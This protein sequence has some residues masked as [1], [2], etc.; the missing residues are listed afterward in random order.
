MITPAASEL[1]QEWVTKTELMTYVRCPYTYSLLHRGELDPADLFDDFILDLIAQGQEFHDRVDA[2]APTI[3]LTSVE[4]L[5]ELLAQGTIILH[6]PLL[7]NVELKIYGMP[8][9]IDPQGGALWPI[10]YK[11]HKDVQPHDEIEL[12]FYW[13]LLAPRRTK[14]T[15]DP[16]GLMV[17]RR[18][19]EPY[20]VEV[21]IP[22]HRIAQVTSYLALV[23][24]ARITPMEPRLCRC[25]VCTGVRRDEVLQSVTARRHV[26]LLFGVG[27]EYE[28]ALSDLGVHDY[29]DLLEWD[30]GALAAALRQAG[31]RRC[32]P[33]MA[34]R[35][36]HHARAYREGSAQ[37]FGAPPPVGDG[38]IVLDLEYLTQ[39]FGER[40]WLAGTVVAKG[41]GPP[42]V[43]QLWADDTDAD[44]QSLLEDLGRLLDTHPQLPIVTWAGRG[45]DLPATRRAAGRLGTKDPLAGRNHCDLYVWAQRSFRLPASGLGLKGLAEY[46][47]FP[48]N[49]NVTGGME[50]Q[51]LYLR[52]RDE[53]GRSRQ[54]TKQQLLDYNRDDL[55]STLALTRELKALASPQENR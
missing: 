39:P 18:D 34:E 55:D 28:K 16:R 51:G 21:A 42:L 17:L 30:P 22:P 7:F 33:S 35:W 54:D 20:P 14:G 48:R 46:F 27:R 36:Q 49:S 15:D 26:S 9:G 40:V 1:S 45:A 23:R 53:S 11:S 50:A 25:H 6:P 4:E 19:G 8:D 32:S 29:L 24:Q 13:L 10:E 12:A 38:F 47:A 44:E 2:M 41:F 3:E 52:M 43:H 37:F 31:L 5:D